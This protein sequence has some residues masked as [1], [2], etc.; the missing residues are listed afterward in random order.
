MQKNKFHFGPIRAA[1]GTESPGGPPRPDRHEAMSAELAALFRDGQDEALAQAYDKF[2]GAVYHLALTSLGNTA[3]AED[4]VQFTFVGAWQGR[5]TYDPARGSL[6]GWLLGIA[7]RKVVDRLRA[8]AREDRSVESVKA[9]A[10]PPA[11]DTLPDHVIDRLIVA[12]ELAALPGDQR[13]VL[14]LAFYDDLTHR[15][16]AA[17]TGMP[18]GTVKSHLRRGLTR[19]RERWEVDGVANESRGSRRAGADR[20][21]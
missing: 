9:V 21:R 1:T 6:L 5:Q 17:V 18:L 20:A 12:D 19:L 11:L 8:R 14:E 10:D 13:R 15:Q 16:I 3:D 4:V 7:R 2:G